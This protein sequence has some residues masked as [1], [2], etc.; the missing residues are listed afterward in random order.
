MTSS[1][2]QSIVLTSLMSF[3]AVEDLLIGFSPVVVDGSCPF[4]GLSMPPTEGDLVLI[5]GGG[6]G[7]CFAVWRLDMVRSEGIKLV[8]NGENGRHTETQSGISIR[9]IVSFQQ[10]MSM[11]SVPNVVSIHPFLLPALLPDVAF[12]SSA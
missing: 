7:G 4:A 1:E 5:G 2:S 10:Y 8:C 6:S 12:A 11:T 9:R 3:L